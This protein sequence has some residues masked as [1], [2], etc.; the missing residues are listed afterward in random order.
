MP[1]GPVPRDGEVARP[2]AA[3][4]EHPLRAGNGEEAQMVTT[5]LRR[6]PRLDVPQ[7]PGEVLE[8]QDPPGLPD[9]GPT[10]A[11]GLMNTVPMALGSSGMMV[12]F[13]FFVPAGP[14]RWLT[15]GIM[16]GAM[17]AMV[18]GGLF[19]NLGERKRQLNSARR[20]Y[21]RYLSQMREKAAAGATAQ[22]ASLQWR[23]PDPERLA[24]LI[25]SPRLWERRVQDVDFL[26]ARI[27]VGTQLPAVRLAVP[28]TKPIDDLEPLSALA[29]RRFIEAWGSVED[30]PVTVQL[31]SHARILLRGDPD[32]AR[33]MLRAMLAGLATLHTP[34]DLR[35]ALCVAPE[36]L[37]EWRWALWLPHC[38]HPSDTDAAGPVRML[39]EDAAALEEL[40]G[41]DEMDERGAFEPGALPE[42]DEAAWLVLLDGVAVTETSRF[43]GKGYR[44]VTAVSVGEAMPWADHPHTLRLEAGGGEIALVNQDEA[45]RDQ[46][47]PIGPPDE[48]SC[49]R[50]R[51]IARQLAPFRIGSG[52]AGDASALPAQVGLTTL[53]GVGEPEDFDPARIRRGPTAASWLRVPIG[54]DDSGNTV[55]LDIKEA[56]LGGTGPHGML[57]GATGSGK[58]ELLRTLVLSMATCHSSESLNMVLVDFKGGATFLGLE[59]LPHVCA[60]ITN[61]ADELSLV[62]RMQDA[63]HGELVRRQELLRSTGFASL[64]DYERARAEG[65]DLA[66]LPSLFLIVDE[67]SELLSAKRDFINL[68]VM[69][70]RLGRSL[71]VHLLL[72]TQ[73]LDEGRVHQL[74]G[75]LSYRIALRVL[76]SSES[77]SVLGVT[78]AYETPLAPGSGFLKTD[79]MH[80]TRF[81]AAFVS[82][83]VQY[84]AT[85]P[86]VASGRVLREI[87]PLTHERLPIPEQTL[88]DEREEE[89]TL[90]QADRVGTRTVLEV[91]TERLASGGPPAH[92]VWLPP[93]DTPPALDELFGGLAV[94]PGRGLAPT[95]PGPEL[96]VPVGIV[97]KP[98][99]QR[100]E[101]LL[102]DLAGPAG[103]VAVVGGA[104]SGKTTL[105]RT[106]LLALALTHTPE[107]VQFYCLD[108]G[109]GGLSSL[110]GLPHLGGMAVRTDVDRVNRTLAEVLD[111]LA[112]RER[113]LA[114]H[115]ADSIAAYRRMR[116]AGQV[117]GDAF[118]DV[119]LVIDG[120]Y[121]VRT[122]F[123]HL[124]ASFQ[125]IAAR[126]LGL[127]VHLVV[128]SSRWAELRPWL[129]DAL[130]TRFELRLGDPID[131]VVGSRVA[132]TVPAVPGRGITADGLHF[133]GALPQLSEAGPDA[134]QAQAT[135]DV[136]R[137]IREAWQGAT[138]PAVRTL[139]VLLDAADL[140]AAQGEDLQPSSL[141][142]PIGLAEAHLE[143]V[144]HDF[145]RT[146]HLMVYGDHE[147]GKTNLLR[148]VARAV[149][150]RFSPD[151]A[152]LILADYRRELQDC[153][154]GEYL[155]GTAV[156]GQALDRLLAESVEA[157]TERVPG[158][159]VPP[160]QMA[161]RDWWRGPRLF[162]LVDD[163]D[164]V[165]SGSQTPLARLGELSAM[166]ADIGLH[167]VVARSTGG[168]SRIMTDPVVRRLWDIGTPTL[169]LSC[170]KEEGTFL[171]TYRP[172]QLPA[173][174]ANYLTRRG[175]TLLQTGFLADGAPEA[176]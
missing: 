50:A 119:F 18:V 48:L 12:M 153:A 9:D 5:T 134:D 68:F 144:W 139:P 67:F 99:E 15:L 38:Q 136:V 96:L 105:V 7:A 83:K 126:G 58:S 75:H 122:E 108:F 45:G 82:G 13:V 151:G 2:S 20:E 89:A 174:R 62:D 55:E 97:D 140:P 1:R 66:P 88:A 162:V 127:G 87:V 102:A 28:R 172:Q 125:D 91:M 70:C 131:S 150:D 23:H 106:L 54:V 175:T 52:G 142:V 92:Q 129:R 11:S 36:H 107:Q 59:R 149:C 138:A 74:E 98:F 100:W 155:L 164:L 168:A 159:D 22:R 29:L 60:V 118:G 93:L 73:R 128:T 40:L 19:R 26:E 173:G 80:L 63:L 130:G 103:H 85:G 117:T 152:R 49:V 133:L 56:A 101:M 81:K 37:D 121:T 72:A 32:T 77:R 111:V 154:P 34:A 120:W 8:L 65:A 137:R 57:V 160:D 143:P 47:S 114:A 35:I 123:E 41:K 158:A 165:A 148:L 171:G 30:L 43:V 71:G 3:V 39:V 145:G 42:A 76:S 161:R 61:L 116:A 25:R 44:N 78:D 113:S 166:G 84:R 46:R 10:L 17:V 31:R 24:A 95:D 4:T 94:Q 146:P 27:G 167:L 115:G 176:S 6:Q 90:A 51:A 141:R 104:R 53:L 156:S 79:T 14:M 110:A 16:G 169:M 157:L 86:R 135:Q 69:I 109:G 124:D 64:M 147:S 170:P 33:G 163:Y 132:A 112:A 21:L